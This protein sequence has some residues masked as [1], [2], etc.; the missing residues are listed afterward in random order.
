MLTYDARTGKMIRANGLL[1]GVG[2]AGADP[3]P[4][5]KG[6]AGEGVNRPDL[7]ALKSVGPVPCGVY[8]IHGPPFQHPTAGRD[9][10]RLIP[11]EGNTMH[12]RDGFLI[13]GEGHAPGA[14]SQGCMIFANS[15]RWK[16]W[17][18]GDH[19]VRVIDSANPGPSIPMMASH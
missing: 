8:R 6:E 13:H 3:D 18:E 1:L 10:L 12:G 11:D 17:N 5:R 9:V 7:D 4:S 16:I 14:S 2:Y 15:D 19:L